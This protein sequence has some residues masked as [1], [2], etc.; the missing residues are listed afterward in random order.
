MLSLFI[1]F[2]MC[3]FIVCLEICMCLLM[4]LFDSFLVMCCSILVL[5][6]DK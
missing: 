5:W 1:R 4:C 3:V 2:F 6:G